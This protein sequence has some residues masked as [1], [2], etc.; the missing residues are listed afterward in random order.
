MNI[1]FINLQK[2]IHSILCSLLLSPYAWGLFVLMYLFFSLVRLD[3][4]PAVAIDEPW[5]SN[6]AYNTSIGNGIVNTVPGK[7]GGDHFFIP[8]LIFAFFIKCFGLSI[9]SVRFASVC[10]GW[11]STL[12]IF[13][14]FRHLKLSPLLSV[15]GMFSIITGNIY[16]VVFRW[17]RPE[18]FV[19]MLLVWALYHYLRQITYAHP[20]DYLLMGLLTGCAAL[21]HPHALPVVLFLNGFSAFHS[22]SRRTF[23]LLTYQM[24]GVGII[25]AIGLVVT[26]H[27]FGSIH[28]FL[29]SISSQQRIGGSS[30]GY[31]EF[32][33]HNISQFFVSSSLGLK[34]AFILLFELTILLI[35]CFRYRHNQSISRLSFIGLGSFLL[36]LIVFF[37]RRRYFGI[38]SVFSCLT[39]VCILNDLIS[40][41]KRFQTAILTTAFTLY[42]I[43][44]LAGDI[45]LFY[46][47]WH[48]TP[49]K[50]IEQEFRQSIPS[51]SRVLS[52]L[53][54]WTGLE[55][56]QVTV[57]TPASV[58][59]T[60]NMDYVIITDHFKGAISPTTGSSNDL[61]SVRKQETQ[62]HDTMT[63]LLSNHSSLILKL[64]TKGYSTLFI[65]KID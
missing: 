30:T 64:P 65:Y 16:L 24:I 22:I 40:N 33:F 26:Y 9:Y 35:G 52:P 2:R 39:T 47:H 25:A 20:R 36:G 61:Y 15:M 3:S 53:Y 1:F 14:I 28:H 17:G 18:G 10:A 12:G 59:Q 11:L 44:C 6:T 60:L 38:I 58:K 46:K 23:N 45:Y 13:M 63:G 31:V 57:T 37:F 4:I 29:E 49:F 27:N 51:P 48:N 54:F 34:R 42:F 32:L 41:K 62:M 19:I 56:Q 8:S 5:Y 7:W 55:N 50:V 21:T 43:N